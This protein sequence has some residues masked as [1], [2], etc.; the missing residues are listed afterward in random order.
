MISKESSQYINESLKYSIK[1]YLPPHEKMVLYDMLLTCSVLSQTPMFCSQQDV[2][3]F[4]ALRDNCKEADI[5]LDTYVS[6][7]YSY[8]MK[9]HSKGHR[10]SLGYFL[11]D[12]VVEYC[13]NRVHSTK[14]SLTLDNIT[15]DIM[16][17]EKKLRNDMSELSI[18][19][20][21]SF[22]RQVKFKH[23]S[24]IFV[25]YKKYTASPLVAGLDTPYLS[26]LVTILEP[27]FTYILAKNNIFTPH[28]ILK[29]NNSKIEDFSFCPIYFKDRYITGELTDSVLG[30]AAT[31]QG[32]KIHKIFED[33]LKKYEKA[34][35]KDLAAVAT[36][37]FKSVAYSAI[38]EELSEH[39]PFIEKLFLSPATDSILVELVST[40]DEILIEH[41]MNATADGIPFY[42]TADLILVHGTKATILDYKSSK[43]DPKYMPK[44]N[45]KYLNQLSLYASLFRVTRPDIESTEAIIIYTRGK[46][47]RF[48]A[49]LTGITGTRATQ[50]AEMSHKLSN[51]MLQPNKSSCF[52]CRHPSCKMR[53]RDSIWNSD[54]S[55]KE[56][57]VN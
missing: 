18:S 35:V 37:Y 50:I 17:T 42:G 57:M 2:E 41:E 20:A 34:K 29:W 10:L 31:A 19:Y 23:I 22:A 4:I 1:E 8:I 21:Q 44:N 26:K 43:L 46:I 52:L 38:K 5:S 55:K 32:T 12:K 13:G 7:A 30:N 6:C 51:G 49:V 39:T 56:K 24:D 9:Y 25:A 45:E 47:H 27:Y 53:G 14:S 11:N 16:A 15:E 3:A 33:I 54:G 48:S 40:A 28:K 36:R